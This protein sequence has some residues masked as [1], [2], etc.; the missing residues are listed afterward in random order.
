MGYH[1]WIWIAYNKPFDALTVSYLYTCMYIY[2]LYYVIL[3]C[4]ILYCSISNYNTTLYYTIS[5]CIILYIILY[6]NNIIYIYIIFILYYFGPDG[7]RRHILLH[8]YHEAHAHNEELSNSECHFSPLF[9]KKFM[10]A[11]LVRSSFSF[12]ID[13]LIILD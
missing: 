7:S 4:I 13:H 1:Q 10:P 5:Y 3:Y 12:Q 8:S 9:R 2:I 11:S 6:Y